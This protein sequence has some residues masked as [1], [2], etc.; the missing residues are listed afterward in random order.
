MAE[1]GAY[2]VS[3]RARTSQEHVAG[4]LTKDIP[5]I[6]D[7]HTSLVLRVSEVQVFLDVIETSESDGVSV[8]VVEP[9]HAP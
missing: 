5:Y 1:E 3:R 7:G 4:D 8:E 6:Q 9:I 2:H